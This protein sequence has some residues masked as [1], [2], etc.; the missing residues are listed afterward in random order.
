MQGLTQE[1]MSGRHPNFLLCSQGILN[2]RLNGSQSLR[3][4]ARH[5]SDESGNPSIL[6]VVFEAAIEA[7]AT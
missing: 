5:E 2:E 7:A 1:K 3:L 6:P 4:G